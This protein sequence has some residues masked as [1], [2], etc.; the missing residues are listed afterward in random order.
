MLRMRF[1]YAAGL[2]ITAGGALFVGCSDD[3]NAASTSSSSGGSSGGSSGSSGSDGGDGGSSG[4]PVSSCAS[5]LR[6]DTLGGVNGSVVI[7]AAGHGDKWA[8]RWFHASMSIAR[9]RT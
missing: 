1:Q 3:E 9:H 6:V 8:V 5:K 2:V 7:S 4:T